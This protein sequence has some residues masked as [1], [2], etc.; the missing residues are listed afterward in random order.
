MYFLLTGREPYRGVRSAVERML[1]ISRGG[2][3][4]HEL[5][6]RW[7]M[8]EDAQSTLRPS[9]STKRLHKPPSR[10]NSTEPY[11]SQSTQLPVSQNTVDALH[12]SQPD[13]ERQANHR[14]L[15]L[16]IEEEYCPADIDT[17]IGFYS[18]GSPMLRYLNGNQIVDE[19]VMKLIFKMCSPAANDRP[20]IEQIIQQL[21]S[22]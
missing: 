9:S 10:S 15:A 18:D 2:F 8:L 4:E 11:Q 17:R 12:G 16:E 19:R 22:I 21:K 20:Q 3:W 6:M 5:G 1:L 14:N 7:K 13:L